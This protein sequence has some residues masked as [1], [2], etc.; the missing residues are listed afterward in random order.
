MYFIVL[1]NVFY[2]SIHLRKEAGIVFGKNLEDYA[3]ETLKYHLKIIRL[4]KDLVS[5]PSII[6]FLRTVKSIEHQ[7]TLMISLIN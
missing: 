4:N 7:V 5:L 1:L 2:R 3:L 6:I